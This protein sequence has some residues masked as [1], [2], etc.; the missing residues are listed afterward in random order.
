MASSDNFSN[1][2]PANRPP[3]WVSVLSKWWNGLLETQLQCQIIG[4]T[5][6]GW[7]GVLQK[8]VY[9]LNQ[10]LIYGVVSCGQ[11]SK[12]QNSRGEMGVVTLTAVPSDL[13]ETFASCSHNHIFCCRSFFVKGAF[14]SEVMLCG[15]L[16]W[17]CHSVN[18]W[19]VV[20]TE[21][22]CAVKANLFPD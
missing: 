15:M 9:V 7:D 2:T 22:M 13:L 20:M 16:H 10:C 3:M 1:S 17:K 14:W 18:P 8:V 5:L 4:S 11:H 19:M 6:Q 21:A 12:V